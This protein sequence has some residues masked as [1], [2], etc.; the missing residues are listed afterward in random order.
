LDLFPLS[1]WMNSMG[2]AATLFSPRTSGG[3]IRAARCAFLV[4]DAR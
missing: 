2:R 1:Q 3:M 4:A